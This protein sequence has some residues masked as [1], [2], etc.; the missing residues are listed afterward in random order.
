MASGY[1]RIVD[2]QLACARV[3]L[4]MAR[5]SDKRFPR[6]A[7]LNACCL[8][9]TEALLAYLHELQL[10]SCGSL[11]ND[12]S[13]SVIFSELGQSPQATDFRVNE[14]I[15]LA[16]SR[17]SWMDNLIRLQR[18]FRKPIMHEQKR[19]VVEMQPA[20]EKL[21]ATS[22]NPSGRNS[23]VESEIMEPSVDLIAEIIK[24][25]E[26]LIITHREFSAEY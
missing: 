14:V 23:S 10:N 25:M 2:H 18:Y 16:F 22:T 9:L 17:Q 4:D 6:T 13:L 24:G 15:T 12:S 5:A 21:I 26:N 7:C 19:Q 1:A 3:Q 8:H 11:Q 20:D